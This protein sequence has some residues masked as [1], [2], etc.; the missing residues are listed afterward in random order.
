MEKN[1]TYALSEKWFMTDGNDC[2]DAPF[3]ETG[4]PRDKAIPVSLPHFTHLSL[5]DHVGISW[6]ETVFTLSELPGK[7]RIALLCFTKTTFTTVTSDKLSTTGELVNSK[8]TVVCT[9]FT[10]C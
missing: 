5:E 1:R 4:I 9:T 2:P 3:H 8:K 7:G 6:Y 10:S